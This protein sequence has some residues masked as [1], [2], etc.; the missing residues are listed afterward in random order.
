MKPIGTSDTV[1][2]SARSVT[3]IGGLSRERPSA[4][5]RRVETTMYNRPPSPPAHRLGAL[6]FGALSALLLV[7][8]A[9]GATGGGT[10]VITGQA[11][12]KLVTEGGPL[13]L[14]TTLR[15]NPNK[16]E[17]YYVYAVNANDPAT[18]GHVTVK[19][20]LPWTASLNAHQTAGDK[21]K[22]NLASGVLRYS[23]TLPRTFA[24]AANKPILGTTPVGLPGNPD[25]GVRT[26]I[27]YFLLHVSQGSG[28]TRF[29][30]TLTYGIGQG[31]PATTTQ[32]KLTFDFLGL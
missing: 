24:E 21:K 10:V 2:G 11:R 27:H 4:I 19:S 17:W 13:A 23:T 9:I 18:R 20:N 30:A 8:P 29:G 7:L 1:A 22:M 3:T 5:L 26:Y 31:S 32:I 14:V 16:K 25:G 6:V 28:G 15:I 12:S